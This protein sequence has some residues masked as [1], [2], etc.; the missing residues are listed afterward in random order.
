MIFKIKIKI[1][2][3]ILLFEINIIAKIPPVKKPVKI[4][5]TPTPS[6]SPSPSPPPK[7][8]PIIKLPERQPIIDAIIKKPPQPVPEPEKQKELI[9]YKEELQVSLLF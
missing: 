7:Q 6:P 9:I 3:K 4:Q 2:S 8:K 1:S 5:K